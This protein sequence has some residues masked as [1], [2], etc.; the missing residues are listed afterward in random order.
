MGVYKA[1]LACEHDNMKLSLKGRNQFHR[2]GEGKSETVGKAEGRT[3]EGWRGE[4]GLNKHYA[5]I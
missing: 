4:E 2:E 3:T 5:A 1:G